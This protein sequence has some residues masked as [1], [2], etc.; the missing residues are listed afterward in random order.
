MRRI[1]ILNEH[2]EWDRYL[3]AELERHGF[4]C[5]IWSL[6]DLQ[7]AM[8]RQPSTHMLYLNRYSPSSF[9]RG[10]S[11]AKG[12]ALSVVAW[13]EAHGCIVINGR[14]AL[15]LEISKVAQSLAC[16]SVGLRF[17]YTEMVVG[18]AALKRAAAAW[19]QSI[20]RQTSPLV[21]KPNC[22]GSGNGVRHYATS[23]ALLDA[24][25]AEEMVDISPDGVVLLQQFIPAD[26]IYRLEFVGGN[27]LY[28]VRIRTE[29]GQFNH[30]PCEQDVAGACA[31][32]RPPKFEIDLNFPA[33]DA[34]F[35]LVQALKRMLRAHLVDVA[36][37]EAI[38]DGRN[39][40]WVIDCNCCNT[41]YN[42]VAEQR[43]NVTGGNTAIAQWVRGA[44]IARLEASAPPAPLPNLHSTRPPGAGASDDHTPRESCAPD[45]S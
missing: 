16:R 43:A 29:Q 15:E 2:A 23:Q 18:P 42:V 8:L 9:W 41:N 36:A 3:V 37:I 11:P 12:A 34:E 24:L 25:D 33:E 22:G 10:N 40:W 13:L 6:C 39:R 44:A 17:P 32:G 31:V 28:T 45:G 30:C 26:Y 4:D 35:L 21:L 1:C 7:I 14:Q 20:S 19:G 38:R 27:L 5:T